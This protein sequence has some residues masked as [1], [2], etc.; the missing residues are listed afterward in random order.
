MRRRMKKRRIKSGIEEE[1]KEEGRR[2]IKRGGRGREGRQEI[3][4][5]RQKEKD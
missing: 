5:E 3:Y 1:L 2:R 4:G